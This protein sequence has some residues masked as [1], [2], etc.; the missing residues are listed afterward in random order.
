LIFFEVIEGG[1][2]GV[3]GWGIG[4]GEAEVEGFFEEELGGIGE[5]FEELVEVDVEG[6]FWGS[7]EGMRD[8]G[9]RERALAGSGLGGGGVFGGEAKELG[10]GV[11]EVSGVEGLEFVLGD[12]GIG[13]REAGFEVFEEFG[14]EDGRGEERVIFGGDAGVAEV[15]ELASGEDGFEE[16]IAIIVAERAVASARLGG[17]E[18][19][20]RG[21]IAARESAVIEAEEADDGEGDTAHGFEA[22]ESDRAGEE[23]ATGLGIGEGIGEGG[24]DDGEGDR[25]IEIGE[26]GDFGEGE[27]GIGDGAEIIGERVIAGEEGEESGAEIEGPSG[28][29]SR[30][31]EIGGMEEELFGEFDEAAKGLGELAFDVG[32]GED[33][34]EESG[35]VAWESVAEEE[36]GE[37]SAPGIFGERGEAERGAV[38]GIDAPADIGAFDPL[39]DEGEIVIGELELGAD[40]WGIEES[41]DGGGREAGACEIEAME[42]GI[43]E[44]I[45]AGEGA[46]GDG[47]GDAEVG[48]FWGSE[49]G[50]DER[51]IGFEV[52]DGDEDIAW[53]EVRLIDEELK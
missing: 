16:E 23:A 20:G 37:A 48:G 7:G 49:D 35:G 45:F 5:E 14:D 47:V 4:G 42:E 30:G 52:G 40:G 27:D 1:G 8:E 22:R 43:G 17:D 46:I 10:M 38:V 32:I 13:E 21:V 39:V 19:E 51:R 33:P 50:I 24:A 12:E 26:R 9:W 44:E 3:M 15:E 6:F 28:E 34:G 25:G 36:A 41:E 31:G 11:G 29:G 53:G 18:I 2:F